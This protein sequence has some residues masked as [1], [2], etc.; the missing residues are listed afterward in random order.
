MSLFKRAYKI[1]IG[2]PYKINFSP[3]NNT[4]SR[5]QQ[6]EDFYANAEPNGYV[7]TDHQITFTINKGSTANKKTSEI[8]IF[9]LDERFVGYLVQNQ[10]K[11]LV[12]SFQAGY[13]GDLKQIF[14]GTIDKVVDDFSDEN[15]K[16]TLTLGDGVVNLK[17]AVTLRSY[18]RNT[19]VTTIIQ[20]MIDDL[21]LP[22]GNYIP[23]VELPP[24]L[25]AKTYHG[26]TSTLLQRWALYTDSRFSVQNGA[27]YFIPKD[28]VL[29]GER[30]AFLSADSGLIDTPKPMTKNAGSAEKNSTDPKTGLEVKSLLNGSIIPESSVYIQS[31]DID[32]AYK[33]LKVTYKGD[34]EGNSWF[35]EMEVVKTDKVIK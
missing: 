29:D 6:L 31:G 35:N 21:G 13:E 14:K 17:E 23:P 1:L 28:A 30:S 34:Y 20:D 32:G 18:P 27:V 8:T 16:T 25:T 10:D 3:T 5:V 22:V 11:K 2:D 24:L 19:P 4:F 12:I 26:H 15:R 33:V 7:I 9:N